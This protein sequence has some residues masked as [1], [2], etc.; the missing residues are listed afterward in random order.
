MSRLCDPWF[1][2]NL[3]CPVSRRR[4]EID[5]GHLASPEG[6]RYPVVQGIPVMLIPDVEQTLWVASASLTAAAHP[7][8][9]DPYFLDTLG[10]SDVERASIRRLVAETGVDTYM[11]PVVTWIVAQTNGLAYRKLVGTLTEYP[12]P[13][14]RLPDS[15]GD[16]L[17][18][19]GSNWGRWSV[20]AA[21]KGYRPVGLDPSLGAVL[22]MR[23]LANRFNLEIRGVVGDARYL[24]FRDGLFDVGFS[25]GVLQHFPPTD[26]AKAVSEFGRVLKSG[27]DCL[28]QMPTVFGL[29][30]LY[31]ELRRGFRKPRGFEV[32]YYT[33]PAL[34]RLFGSAIGIA[35]VSVHCFFGIG[36]EAS[37]RKFF[38][39]FLRLILAA[40][41]LLRGLSERF[42]FLVYLADSVYVASRKP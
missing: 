33:I 1:L 12:I 39:P 3:V 32:R 28:V 26:A 35:R 7:D 15:R 13:H 24:P 36:W 20:A 25:H 6:R 29:R 30:C 27:G 22:A 37:D 31:N 5:G 34:R 18:D 16:L 14:L 11:D 4:L 10:V 8:S 17:L 41:E 2:E 42:P 9:G 23:R 19:V 38:S 40:S 21:L